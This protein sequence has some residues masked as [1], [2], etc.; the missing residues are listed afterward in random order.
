MTPDRD[1]DLLCRVCSTPTAPFA[2]QRVLALVERWARRRNRFQVRVDRFGN[3]LVELPGSQRHPRLVLVAHADHP[4]LLA[5]ATRAD[6]VL[7]A[8]F[9]G[10]VLPEYLD[11]AEVEFFGSGKP[12]RARVLSVEPDDRGRASHVTLRAT[13]T[14]PPGTPGMFAV[15][16][17][18]IRGKR[19]HARACDDLAGVAAALAA[20]DHLSRRPATASAALLLTRG[21]EQ[22][23]IGAIAACEH[24]S[25]IR[26][27]DLLVSIE[28]SAEQP[29]ARQGEGAII[30]VGD[31][32]SVFDSSLTAFLDE[33]AGALRNG[34][35][36]RFQRALMPGGT[37]EA[38]VFD[39]WGYRSAAVCVPL[40]HY[41]NMDRARR[42]AAAEHIHLDDWR[43]LVTLLEDAA[44]N[45]H[46]FEPG[47][48]PLRRRLLE[49]FERFR[50]LL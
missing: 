9:H 1:I 32:T 8:A 34:Q 28:C 13:R 41:H 21:E 31:R 19:L 16:A 45:A 3:R 22:G 29:Y 46:R 20:L 6:G 36:P 49:R 15:G 4:G 35:G 48:K 43:A 2:E 14:V 50:P 40:G 42:R 17:P 12:V 44:R 47:M 11:D 37:C 18:R 38:T 24:P 7:H 27:S 39:A 10:G 30:R 25:L 5:G 33:R 23:F 26:R